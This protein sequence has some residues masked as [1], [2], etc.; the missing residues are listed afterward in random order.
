MR[1]QHEV[2][3]AFG[4][5]NVRHVLVGIAGANCWARDG[6]LVASHG[7]HE[8]VLEPDPVSLSAAWL[9]LRILGYTLREGTSR[10]LDPVPDDFARDVVRDRRS[11]S[12]YRMRDRTLFDLHTKIPGFT[13]EELWREHRVFRAGEVELHVA[14]LRHIL[15]S[16]HQRQQGF[17]ELA[18]ATWSQGMHDHY[19]TNP[20][21]TAVLAEHRRRHGIVRA[22]IED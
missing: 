9:A 10:L 4:L 6:S 17:D 8:I 22:P 16:M 18:V 13:F 11:T 19:V 7:P 14:R 12:A 2:L 1:P 3:R 20:E 5:A 15:A 21:M